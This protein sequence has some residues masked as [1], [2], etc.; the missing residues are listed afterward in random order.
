MLWVRIDCEG[1]ART[2]LATAD[3]L[4]IAFVEP[5]GYELRVDH[6]GR[7]DQVVLLLRKGVPVSDD[8]KSPHRARLA[9]EYIVE[10]GIPFDRLGVGVD[11]PLAFFVEVLEGGQ[12]KDRAPRD[13]AIALAR[14]SPDFE[15]IMWDV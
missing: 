1:L 8:P 15:Q 5:V 9:I 13:G 12:S 10:A 11:E 7:A 4:R 6:P 3:V 2:A 14:P